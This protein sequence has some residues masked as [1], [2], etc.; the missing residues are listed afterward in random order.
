M[1]ARKKKTTKQIQ[2]RGNA[3]RGYD[4]GMTYIQARGGRG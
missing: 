1:T 4:E 2:K 3:E